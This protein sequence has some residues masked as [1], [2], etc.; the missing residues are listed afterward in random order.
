MNNTEKLGLINLTVVLGNLDEKNLNL[1]IN[2]TNSEKLLKIKELINA[3]ECE[4]CG[5][6]LNKHYYNIRV[7]DDDNKHYCRICDKIDC[8]IIYGICNKCIHNKNIHITREPFSRH[9]VMYTVSY[10][11]KNLLYLRGSRS[12]QHSTIFDIFT[13]LINKTEKIK[14]YYSMNYLL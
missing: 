13:P 5:I 14:D 6:S 3:K 10:K 2:N 11:C 12:V 1:I 8:R 7:V 9:K 4:T